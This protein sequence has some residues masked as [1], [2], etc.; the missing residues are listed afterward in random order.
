[1]TGESGVKIPQFPGL[2]RIA[3]ERREHNRTNCKTVVDNTHVDKYQCSMSRAITAGGGRG[4]CWSLSSLSSLVVV[5]VKSGSDAK[6]RAAKTTKES[7]ELE[8]DDSSHGTREELGYLS[9][10]RD[11]GALDVLWVSLSFKCAGVW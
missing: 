10:R 8:V 3:E 2:V 5:V 9:C 11:S 6:K 1:M 4:E 7:L